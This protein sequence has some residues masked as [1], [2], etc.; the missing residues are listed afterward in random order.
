[1]VQAVICHPV[2]TWTNTDTV[3]NWTPSNEFQLILNQYTHIYHLKKNEMHENVVSKISAMVR[4]ILASNAGNINPVPW[5][6]VSVT[7]LKIGK[8][9][10]QIGH[11]NDNPG[12]GHQCDML[13]CSQVNALVVRPKYTLLMHSM[14]VW[15]HVRAWF[16]C[17]P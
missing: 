3:V 11:Q 14:E 16:R 1:M 15:A 12:I 17:S 2:I 8:L 13:C 6:D 10:I 4:T 9:D 7:H 5:N